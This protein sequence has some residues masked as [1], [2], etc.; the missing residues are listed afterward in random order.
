M[1][2]VT[3]P[4]ADA[5]Q[6][7][8]GSGISHYP[9]IGVM[10]VSTMWMLGNAFRINNNRNQCNV[11]WRAPHPMGEPTFN[12]AK[13]HFYL[14]KRAKHVIKGNRLRPRCE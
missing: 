9:H 11:L 10:W 7:R 12:Y 8:E 6:A 4:I 2:Q 3:T 1:G 14:P 5:I 13:G